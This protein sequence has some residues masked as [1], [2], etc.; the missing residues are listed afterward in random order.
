MLPERSSPVESL[1]VPAAPMARLQ[2]A[3]RAAEEHLRRYEAALHDAFGYGLVDRNCVTQLLASLEG[4]IHDDGADQTGALDFIPFISYRSMLEASAGAQRLEVP[5]YR[6]TRLEAMYAVENDIAVWLRESNT[7]SSTIY[8]PNERGSFFLF[9]TEGAAPVR[10]ILGAINFSAAA[11]QLVFGLLKAPFDRGQTAW[12]ALKGVAFSV[13]ELLFV[14][15]RKGLLDYAP[16]QPPRTAARPR[17]LAGSNAEYSQR[18]ASLPDRW[19]DHHTG[20]GTRV[21]QSD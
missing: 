1:P 3:R 10:P 13:P 11:G 21:E 4:A 7:L 6:R 8:R 12:S 2:A 14:D 19:S 15:L 5:S 16:S 20:D 18:T 9:F 17:Q